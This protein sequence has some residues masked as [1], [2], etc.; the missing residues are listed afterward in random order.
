MIKAETRFAPSILSQMAKRQEVGADDIWPVPDLF[1]IADMCCDRWADAQPD[2]VALIDVRHDASLKHWTYAELLR[3][4]TKLAHYFKL[5]QI[6]RGDRVAVLLPQG[7]EVL[8]AHFAA[9]RIG[10]IILPLFTLFGPDALAYRLRDSGAKLTITDAD[11][12]DK[13][14]SILHDLPEHQQILV[15]G[16]DDKNKD[17]QEQ[18]VS[19]RN[20]WRE[21]KHMPDTSLAASSRPDDPAMLIYTSG[22][23][24]NPKGALHAHRFLLGHLP[25][26]EISHQGFPKAGDKGWTP[27]DWAWIG[28]LMDLALPCLYYG[29][30]LVSYR[31]LKF[32]PSAAFQFIADHQIRNMFL[33]PTALK[34]MRSY[35]MTAERLPGLSI[36]T[37]A[38]GGEALGSSL[39][40]WAR[41][42]L[43]VEVNEIYGQTECNLVICTDRGVNKTLPDGV[44]GRAVLGHKLCILTP[45]GQEAKTGEVGEIAVKTPDPVMFLGYWNKPED[46]R[47]KIKQGWLLTGDLG[48]QDK[49]G[50]FTFVARDDDIITSS[51]YRVG[52]TEIENCLMQH[53]SV[54][55]AAVIGLPD[56]IRTETVTACIVLASGT[57]S[58]KLAESLK[59]LVRERL[60]AHLVPRQIIW[61]DDLPLTATG[62]I[63]R[64]ALRES[65]LPQTD[66]SLD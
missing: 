55:L 27:A 51:G 19:V 12:I 2:R 7:P 5:H 49:N 23:T 54:S 41:K 43:N 25:N 22:T 63:R 33:P 13:L 62:K 21:L 40:G 32:D 38:S 61:K 15:C 4:A 60:A 65:L 24:G 16:A 47:E 18:T 26:I 31:Q 17:K 56:P 48:R 8:I 44:M 50:F 20:F 10:A 64:K 42:I 11:S 28:G 53:P 6:V 29:V 45:E 3:A 37:I 14:S 57:G 36:R 59:Q 46:T 34:L 58:D 39:L 35:E 66:S 1:N 9:Y 30:P 52:P